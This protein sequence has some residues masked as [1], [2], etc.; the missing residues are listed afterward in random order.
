M[1]ASPKHL[2][3]TSKVTGQDSQFRGEDPFGPTQVGISYEDWN[4]R[5]RSLRSGM[6][7]RMQSLG[8]TLEIDVQPSWRGAR[9]RKGGFSEEE[10]IKLYGGIVEGYRGISMLTD[11][12]KRMKLDKDGSGDDGDGGWIIPG[13]L[14]VKNLK[15]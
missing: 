10:R 12:I 15:F 1:V 4:E 8:L 2:W 14:L 7:R 11:G 9:K 5:K 6:K 3:G 13:S